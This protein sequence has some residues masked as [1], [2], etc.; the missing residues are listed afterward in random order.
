MII[1]EQFNFPWQ[2][3]PKF[4]HFVILDTKSSSTNLSARIRHHYWNLPC[5]VPG[6]MPVLAVLQF[7]LDFLR[8][9]PF[10]NSRRISPGISI[11]SIFDF[12]NFT[13]SCECNN[14]LKAMACL[15]MVDM[16]NH[17]I[18]QDITTTSVH[19]FLCT[20]MATRILNF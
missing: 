3:C 11:C 2:S 5:R 17:S 13:Y 12:Q 20:I 8:E 14:A 4:T 15:Y 6:A 10:S 1:I 16:H 18:S 19:Q 9:F 7:P